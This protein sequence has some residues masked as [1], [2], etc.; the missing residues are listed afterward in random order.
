MVGQRLASESKETNWKTYGTPFKTSSRCSSRLEPAE[1]HKVVIFTIQGGHLY[2]TRQPS[3]LT[4]NST[5]SSVNN[6]IIII[7]FRREDTIY[8]Q[9]IVRSKEYKE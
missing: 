1:T 8:I 2:Y 4:T 9:S 3:L 6:V 7:Y 5:T